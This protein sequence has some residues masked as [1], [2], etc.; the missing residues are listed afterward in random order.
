MAKISVSLNEVLRDFLGQLTYT[1][2]KYIKES[3][4]KEGEVTN[5]NLP[6][7]YEF[8]SLS[9]FN[10]FVYTEAALEIF[11]HADT[12]SENLMNQFN[13]LVMDLKDDEEHEIELVS[14]EVDKGIPATFFF[15]SKTGCKINKVRFVD[16][17]AN[18]WGDSDVLITANP[19][20]LANKPNGKVSV[21]IKAS[22]NTDI[23]ADFVLDSIL[24][25]IKDEELRNKILNTKIIN[26]EEI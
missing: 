22:Y 15:L 4:I 7:F 24:D 19:I 13:I 10:K 20:A 26:Y 14:R 6:E 21:K 25:F 1:Y 9:D 16:S 8:K 12:M 2:S 17:N 5:F 3:P 11:G 23:P 18:E